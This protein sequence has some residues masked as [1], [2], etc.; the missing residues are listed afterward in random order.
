MYGA[1]DARCRKSGRGDWIR[2]SDLVVPNQA[3]IRWWVALVERLATGRARKRDRGY[4]NEVVD[5]I[6]RDQEGRCWAA[7]T[8]MVQFFCHISHRMGTIPFRLYQCA[9]ASI[10]GTGISSNGSI[11]G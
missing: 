7:L 4:F 1:A 6:L 5:L 3:F 9:R 2:T 10:G 8:G 11:G